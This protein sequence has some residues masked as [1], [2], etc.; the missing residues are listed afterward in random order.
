[1]WNIIRAQDVIA[2]I[3]TFLSYN[4]EDKEKQKLILSMGATLLGV[5]VAGLLE[6]IKE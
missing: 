6:V 5:S 1:M 2:T 4:K 3:K